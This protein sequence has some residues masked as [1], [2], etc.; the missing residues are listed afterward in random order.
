MD[1][2]LLRTARKTDF[3]T[4]CLLSCLWTTGL[5]SYFAFWCGHARD[6]NGYYYVIASWVPYHSKERAAGG[7]LMDR[8]RTYNRVIAIHNQRRPTQ[9]TKN[10]ATRSKEWTEETFFQASLNVGWVDIGL[11]CS[12]RLSTFSLNACLSYQT[13]PAS[14]PVNTPEMVRRNS[15]L[16]YG[17]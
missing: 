14:D 3:G 6:S 4:L 11:Y 15:L 2:V 16:V 5:M 8:A 13:I 10:W 1:C 9:P 17:T 7:G 12:R